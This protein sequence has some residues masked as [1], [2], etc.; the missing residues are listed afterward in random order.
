MKKT[1]IFFNG[2]PVY[3]SNALHNMVKMI[4]IS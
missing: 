2:V 4:S 3:P 1:S